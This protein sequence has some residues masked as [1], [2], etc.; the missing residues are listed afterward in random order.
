MGA[1]LGLCALVVVLMMVVGHLF[2]AELA[3]ITCP[4]IGGEVGEL[5]SRGLL[6][7]SWCEY[8]TL[9]RSQ[10]V[11]QDFNPLR[12]WWSATAVVV[13]SIATVIGAR[14]VHR[15]FT[16]RPRLPRDE[17]PLPGPR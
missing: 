14:R 8:P 6:S 9:G 4:E 15:T 3:R 10:A 2:L 13:L 7:T 5:S 17:D 1:A 11:I 12:P 16:R